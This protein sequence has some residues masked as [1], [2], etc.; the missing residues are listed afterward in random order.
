MTRA[1]SLPSA[2]EPSFVMH[3]GRQH[4]FLHT[5]LLIVKRSCV[6]TS[7][8]FI[9]RGGFIVLH[10]ITDIPALGAGGMGVVL[11]QIMIA[12]VFFKRITSFSRFFS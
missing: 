7:C 4:Q 6:G 1:T 8:F 10:G 3:I 5:F 9:T 12:P 2:A 11:R